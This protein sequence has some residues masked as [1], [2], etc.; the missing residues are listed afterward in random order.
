MYRWTKPV[1]SWT[2]RS[3]YFN[4]CRGHRISTTADSFWQ[5]HFGVFDHRRGIFFRP[6]LPVHIPLISRGILDLVPRP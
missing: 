1:R 3:S 2:L 6:G 5:E 4:G